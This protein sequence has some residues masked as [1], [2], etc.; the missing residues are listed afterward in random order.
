MPWFRV[1]DQ[2]CLSHKALTAGNRALGLWVRAGS[3]A[4]QQLTD[5]HIPTAAV[6]ALGGT[7]ADA[8]A[9][10]AAGLWHEAPGGYAFHQW[11][12]W[13]PSKAEL[14][15]ERERTR[16]RVRKWRAERRKPPV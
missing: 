12:E 9:L 16:D 3:W 2:L 14:E 10:V 11:E 8:K 4:M 6:T 13:Q 7:K 1:D 5:G 15:E